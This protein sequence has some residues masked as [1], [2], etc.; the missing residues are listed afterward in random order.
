MEEINKKLQK[1]R[2]KLINAKDTNKIELYNLKMQQYLIL[3]KNLLKKG[4]ENETKNISS[5]NINSNK[6]T[7]KTESHD[8]HDKLLSDVSEKLNEINDKTNTSIKFYNSIENIIAK[9]FIRKI[10][11]LNIDK[12]IDEI[13]EDLQFFDIDIIYKFKKILENK[14][15]DKRILDAINKRLV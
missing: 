4:G 1:Y 9:Q 2:E 8:N 10:L 11:N 3:Q 12:E 15:V 7:N 14:N 6:I 5:N 13:I